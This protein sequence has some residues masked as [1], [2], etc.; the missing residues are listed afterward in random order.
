VLCIGVVVSILSIAL[1]TQILRLLTNDEAVVQAGLPYLQ[2]M[3]ISYIFFCLSQILISAMRGVE[4]AKVGMY[5]S[6]MSLFVNIFLNWVLIFGHLG[7]PALGITGAAIA[8]LIARIFECAVMVIY[9]FFI[10]KTLHLRF[11][12]LGLKAGV[13]G[14]D[15]IKYGLP[16]MAGDLV[17]SANVFGQG[18]IVGRLSAEAI[19][20]SSI[21]GMMNN[22]T[23]IWIMG[24]SAAVGILTGKTVGRGEFEKMKA[25]A[26]TIQVMFLIIGVASGILILLI[27]GPFISLYDI[28]DQAAIY[29]DQLM[30][31]L[32]VSIVGTC[33]QATGL[34][35][36]VKSGGDTGFVFKN[37]SIFVFLV[38]LPASVLALVLNAPVWV[39]FAC[40]KCDQVLKCF[41][42]VVKINRFNWM[43]KLTREVG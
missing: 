43:K 42:A 39:V 3:G 17:W 18:I 41:V 19:A 4:N 31:V 38:V 16:V 30:C 15:F 2:I 33:Y 9:T 23:F 8:T 10:E 25:Y 35:G 6:L 36:L 26:K 20:A 24:L 12:D 28:S 7:F 5:V 11:V 22:L 13:L 37:D 40:L 32:S 27:K 34:S 21:M 14:K 1:P 29:A